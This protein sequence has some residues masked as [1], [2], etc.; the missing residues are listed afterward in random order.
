MFWR[1]LIKAFI[2]SIDTYEQDMIAVGYQKKNQNQDEWNHLNNMPRQ[3]L[4]GAYHRLPLSHMYK[5]Y[6]CL[7]E[8]KERIN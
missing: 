7:E 2:L 3:S 4:L 1:K 5:S 8:T 6:I